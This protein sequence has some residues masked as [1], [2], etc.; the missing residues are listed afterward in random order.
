MEYSY[1]GQIFPIHLPFQSQSAIRCL[2]SW[3]RTSCILLTHMESTGLG[4]GIQCPA[5]SCS[6]IHHKEI[7]THQRDKH[8]FLNHLSRAPKN[9]CK[10]SHH[11]FSNMDFLTQWHYYDYARRY[12]LRSKIANI[13]WDISQQTNNPLHTILQAK[14]YPISNF[15]NFF[16]NYAI[17]QK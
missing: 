1:P 3:Y 2:F 12:I 13:K 8:S 11:V 7:K 15:N 16:S 6:G 4:Q 5:Q 17:I 9:H 10:S 14:N